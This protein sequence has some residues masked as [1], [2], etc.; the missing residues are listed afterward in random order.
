VQRAHAVQVASVQGRDRFDAEP[1]AH[2][3]DRGVG[4]TESAVCRRRPSRSAP[5]ALGE[6][7]VDAL[8]D[9]VPV[10][11]RPGLTD[12]AA[13]ASGST[14]ARSACSAAGP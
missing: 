9:V 12:D 14:R 5:E 1:F 6:Q 4:A 11:R 2:G 7:F 3:D 10:A 13:A 8:R